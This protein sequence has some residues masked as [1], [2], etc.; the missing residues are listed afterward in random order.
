[1]SRP[2]LAVFGVGA[3]VLALLSMAIAGE[4]LVVRHAIDRPDAIISL[5]SHEWERLPEAARQARAFTDAT[6]YLTIPQVVTIFTCHDC[7]NRVARLRA[8][9][10]E[11]SRVQT[12]TLRGPGTYAEAVSSLDVAKRTGAKRLL[13]VTSPYHTRRSLAVFRKVFE[14][15]G[16]A[17]G[18]E[19]AIASSQARPSTWWWHA[20]DRAYVPYEWAALVYYAWAY[21]INPLEP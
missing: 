7:A 11:E 20:D 10:V 6:V 3:I 12:L 17:I 16:V 13:I 19:P 9:G 15:S 4:A 2:R 21:G 1:V 14:D 8:L 18:I 5:A